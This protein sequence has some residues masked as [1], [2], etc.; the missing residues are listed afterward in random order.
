MVHSVK[1]F[2]HSAKLIAAIG[3]H[4]PP[5]ALGMAQWFDYCDEIAPECKSL[6]KRLRKLDFKK[7]AESLAKWLKNLLKKEPPPNTINGLWFG[8]YNPILGDGEPSCQMYAGGSS[9]FDARS[10]SNEW[11]CQLSWT[12]KGRYSASSVLTDL[13]RPVEAIAENQVF[14]LGEAFLCHG[15]LALVVSHWCNGPMGRAL[16]GNATTRAIVIGHDSG[17]SYRIAV[18]GAK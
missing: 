15:Y 6:W 7:D 18:L 11:V 13:S 8:L 14:Y 10:D 1:M 5:I 2:A 12:P 16:L 3:T 9:A 17:D 4:P